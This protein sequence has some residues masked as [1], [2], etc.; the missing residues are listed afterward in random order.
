MI[1]GITTQESQGIWTQPG[2]EV[3]IQGGHT[4]EL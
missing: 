1:M 2:Q 4:P 3:Q